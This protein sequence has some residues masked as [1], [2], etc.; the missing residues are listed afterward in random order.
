MADTSAEKFVVFV[1]M[2]AFGALV[3]AEGDNLDELIPAFE[4]EELY[5]G[6]PSLLAFRFTNFHR[7]IQVAC[8]TLQKERNGTA[9]VFSDSAFLV[10]D[11]LPKAVDLSRTLMRA[12]V[13]SYVPARIGIARGTFRSLRFASDT[14]TQ[15]AYHA[16][17]FL[18]T[19]VVRAYKT[20][21]CG[22]P[23]VR[24]FLHPDLE[25]L[26]AQETLDVVAVS[27]TEKANLAVVSE[28]NYMD[29]STKWSSG[30]E[31]EDCLLFDGVSAMLGDSIEKF[32]YHYM[33]TYDAFNVMRAQRGRNAYP[34]EKFLNRSNYMR[35]NGFWP[36]EEK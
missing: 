5:V 6:A 36:P 2:M 28:V 23:G 16:A 17:Q 29:D 9:I 11:S 15:T 10:V 35:D 12:L 13:E 3:E 25:P 4:A 26:A 34:W 14:S 27:D 21:R 33:S 20:E 7:C 19:G 24:A 8:S 31:Y 18:G 1:D 22:I 30:P 32:H